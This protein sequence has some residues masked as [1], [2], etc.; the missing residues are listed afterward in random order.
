CGSA[1]GVIVG[2]NC[3][4]AVTLTSR[5]VAVVWSVGGN[6]LTGGAS[7]DEAE[8]PNPNGGSADRIFVSRSR[9]IVAATAFD[10]V[11]SWI[12]VNIVA[13]RLL[14]SGQLP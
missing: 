6:A 5:A 7:G 12:P 8:N 11:V 13:N 3:G 10:D 1:T 14:A 4:T 9:S 2:L